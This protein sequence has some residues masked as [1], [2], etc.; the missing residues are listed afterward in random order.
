MAFRIPGFDPA[1]TLNRYELKI[2]GLTEVFYRLLIDNTEIGIYSK[3]AWLKGSTWD[4]YERDLCTSRGQRILR[5]VAEKNDV[6][7]KRWRTVQIG[8]S[9]LPGMKAVDVQRAEKTRL[10]EVKPELE[11]LDKIIAA[12]EQTIHELCQ[13]VPR[14]FRLERPSPLGFEKCVPTSLVESLENSNR[15]TFLFICCVDAWREL[16]GLGGNC[17][18]AVG[19]NCVLSMT[20]SSGLQV[21]LNRQMPLGSCSSCCKFLPL[22]SLRKTSV[23]VATKVG[24][25]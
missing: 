3:A 16:R 6:F 5:A 8:A 19:G 12:D 7:F 14:V 1:T 20:T 25:R 21:C 18:T 4:L 11:R 13:P 17:G 2:T 15:A 22:F 24:W 10:D 23:G 9:I